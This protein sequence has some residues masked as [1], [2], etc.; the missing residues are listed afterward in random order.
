MR[1]FRSIAVSCLAVLASALAAGPAAACTLSLG[2][3]PYEPFQFKDAAGT[4]TGID[5]EVFE[6]VAKEA[7]CTVAK[8]EV[9]WKRLQQDIE[10]GRMDAAMGLQ[11][12]PEREAFGVFS[13]AY[14]RD[15]M[16]L[17]VRKG[18]LDKVGGDGLSAIKGK[19]FKLGIV[20]GY[21]YGTTYEALAADP[22]FAKQV[23]ESASTELNLRKLANKRIDGFIE[24][25]FVTI[26]MARK[27]K[28]AD[29]IEAHPVA[30]QAADAKFMFSKKSV[31][32]KT[33]EAF[34]AAL[35][36]LKA[37]GAI[38]AILAKYLK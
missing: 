34:N 37:S 4:V 12:T 16:V 13:P 14:R 21:E 15:G 22:A 6:A 23:D 26:A 17:W 29:G 25:D 30:V 31:D 11:N 7:G 20:A 2:W 35:A 10:N 33:V 32:P 18:E 19:P 36:R 9:P 24:N 3:E 28:L 27:E 5:V 8:K 38:D 1:I